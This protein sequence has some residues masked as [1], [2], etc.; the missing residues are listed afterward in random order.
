[1]H[2]STESRTSNVQ[3]LCCTIL[4]WYICCKF[5][6]HLLFLLDAHWTKRKWKHVPIYNTCKTKC[7]TNVQRNQ[8]F[9]CTNTQADV[10]IH[11]P[12]CKLT[13]S[14]NGQVA[15]SY[16]YNR[17]ICSWTA[18]RTRKVT[19]GTSKCTTG[20][21]V[22]NNWATVQH[23]NGQTVNMQMYNRQFADAQLW[24][25]CTN[26]QQRTTAVSLQLQGFKRGCMPRSTRIVKTSV[27][28]NVVVIGISVPAAFRGK[29]FKHF[30]NLFICSA[31][32]AR[33]YYVRCARVPL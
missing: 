30:N 20:K 27:G 5:V 33:S 10:Q 32:V 26:A 18:S 11:Q 31:I 28:F 4:L 21:W 14:D 7:K 9:K 2:S 23:V 13:A 17:Q 12:M 15:N 25:K 19:T 6:V 22:T 16:M 29:E 3:R 1:M 8:T 24:H